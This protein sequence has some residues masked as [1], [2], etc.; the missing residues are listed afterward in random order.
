MRCAH[1]APGPMRAAGP[2]C[3][4]PPR[5]ALPGCAI[6]ARS[7]PMRRGC[8][9]ARWSP[10][11]SPRAT[12]PL[13]QRSDVAGARIAAWLGHYDFFFASADDVF[14]QRL[15][16]RL[17]ADAR[18]LSAALPAEEVDARALTALKGLIAAAVALP[19]HAG[20]LIRALRFLPQEIARQ[21]LPDGSHAERSPAAHLAALQ[22]LTEIRALLQ[23]AQA[24]PPAALA[25]AIERMA[26]AL[27]TLA[28]RRRRARTVQWQQGRQRAGDRPGADP[29]RARRTRSGELAGRRVP[30]AAGRADAADRR[31]RRAAAAGARSLRACRHAGRWK[32]R[33]GGT[34]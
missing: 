21:V 29:C 3:C 9:P 11:G 18:S 15:M 33:S 12:D 22:D 5:T 34:G 1:P 13:A 7:A 28:P 6:C 10:S 17:V 8:A 25:G 23:A 24:Q 27:R 16:G 4:A 31:L 30:A 20:F 14:R 2:R 26:P 32:C 19:E